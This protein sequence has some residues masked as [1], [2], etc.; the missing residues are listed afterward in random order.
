MNQ[1]HP[2][3]MLWAWVLKKEVKAE[4]RSLDEVKLSGNSVIS[5][6]SRDKLC[7][8]LIIYYT[9]GHKEDTESHKE[10]ITALFDF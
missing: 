5:P 4:R 1:V 8:F 3:N 10:R 6:A 2:N 7:K 9:E